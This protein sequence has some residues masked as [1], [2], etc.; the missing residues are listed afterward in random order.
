MSDNSGHKMQSAVL[1]EREK[2]LERRKVLAEFFTP[3]RTTIVG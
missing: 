3:E 2:E 1:R